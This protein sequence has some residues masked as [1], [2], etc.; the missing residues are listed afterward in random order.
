[1]P[2]TKKPEVLR[3]GQRDRDT[4]REMVLSG[5]HFIGDTAKGSGQAARCRHRSTLEV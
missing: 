5:H 2:P 1:M 3:Q 4:I